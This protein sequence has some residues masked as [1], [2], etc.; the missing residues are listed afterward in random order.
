MKFIHKALGAAALS[1]TTFMAWAGPGQDLLSKQCISCHAVTKQDNATLDRLWERKGPDL[2]Y[3]GSK[4]NQ[5]WLQ[6]WL[7]NPTVI[8]PSGVF[9]GNLVKAG[10][11]GELDVIDAAKLP[12]H[13]K[14]SKSDAALAVEALMALKADDGLIEEG[15]YKGEKVNARFAGMLFS[16]LRGCTS[17]HAAKP[18]DGVASGPQL[19]DAGE[20]L[21]PDYVLAYMKDPQK[22]DLHVWMPTLGLNPGDLQKLT[23]YITTLKA[24]EKK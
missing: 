1:L 2:H 18:D 4:F 8:R 10:A 16:K 21:Q 23:G 5:E 15:A 24:G 3:A 12:V 13:M 6:A 20:R 7:E 17:C 19:Y 14:L 9:Y 22:F 11:A